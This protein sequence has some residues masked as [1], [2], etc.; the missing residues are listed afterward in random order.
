MFLV[1]QGELSACR[2]YFV[3][4]AACGLA[5]AGWFFLHRSHFTTPAGGAV[6]D[7]RRN[8]LLGKWNLA[9]GLAN[10]AGIQAYPWIL[11]LFHGNAATG[12]L[13]ACLGVVFIANPVIIGFGNFL[14]PKITHA[15]A[16]GGAAEV[17]RIILKATLVFFAIMS[18]FSVV[19]LFLVAL[20]LRM[21]YG[22]KYVGFDM[23]VGV[24][25]MS[26]LV[27]TVSFPLVFS[28]FVMGRPDAGFKSYLLAMLVTF[29]LG[30]WLVDRTV[31]TAW[32]SV[33]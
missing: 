16:Q 8:W 25:A 31:Y 30:L 15:F 3:S 17:H 21:I 12:S 20:I 5:A 9:G 22:V 33:F 10:L 13:A 32:P 4:G 7:F 11:A 23:V 28:L 29:T 2:A 1:S 18:S 27:E 19:M 26:Q 6:A 24:L 14:G